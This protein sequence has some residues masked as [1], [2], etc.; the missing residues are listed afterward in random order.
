MWRK[1]NPEDKQLRL[2]MLWKEK[3]W[4]L[5]EKAALYFMI[6]NMQNHQFGPYS[7]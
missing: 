3:V 6:Q 7:L 5:L 4:S 1:S 2:Q